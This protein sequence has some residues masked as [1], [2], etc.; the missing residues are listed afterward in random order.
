MTKAREQQVCLDAT[1]YYHCISRCVRRAFLCGHDD[2]SGKSYEHRRQWLEDRILK[3]A[4]VFA[5]DI[6][7]YAVMSNHYH[8]VLRVDR[9]Q[10]LAWSDLEVVERWHSLYKGNLLSQR[11]IR[12][13]ALD[14]AESRVLQDIIVNWRERLF[15]I[16]QFMQLVNEGIA[17]EANAEDQCTGRFWEGR[18]KSQALL[19]EAALAACMTYVDL[20]PVR[21]KMANTPENS[22]H[23][24]I[25]RRIKKAKTVTSPNHIRQQ[26]S[27]LLAFVGNPRANMPKG[28]PF[29]LQDYIELVDWTGRQVRE[30][31]RG[32]IHSQLPSIIDRIGID[33][34][35]WLNVATHF[36]AKFKGLVGRCALVRNT[37]AQF[38]Q[39]HVVGVNACK[40]LLG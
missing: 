10:A 7:A 23:T 37:A 6:C 34:D 11:F 29:R 39:H 15:S 28:L 12:G 35:R 8:V 9:D 20:N 38:G 33:H 1:P 30:N 3:L 22:H 40:A 27:E 4:G 19:D 17:R 36:E 26:P 32:V 5:I 14:K 2:L 18:Y 13:E 31:K 24:S 21:A 16:S 25:K